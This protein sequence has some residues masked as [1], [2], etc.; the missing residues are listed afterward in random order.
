[1]A[2]FFPE[3][4]LWNHPEENISL[5]ALRFNRVLALPSTAEQFAFII[6]GETHENVQQGEKK[7]KNKAWRENEQLE[8]KYLHTQIT[9]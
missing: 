2:F 8:P 9:A 3:N 1:M 7:L 5:S 6:Y 4:S